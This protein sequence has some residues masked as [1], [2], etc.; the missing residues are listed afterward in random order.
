DNKCGKFEI[1]CGP[2]F[3]GKTEELIRRVRRLIYAKKKYVLFNPKIQKDLE[4]KDIASH[5]GNRLT[6]IPINSAADILTYLRENQ[7]I[8]F[9]A[10]DSIHFLDDYITKLLKALKTKGYKIIATGLD[11]DFRGE[12]FGSMAEL[13]VLADNVTKLSSVCTI[14]GKDAYYTQRVIDGEPASFNDEV[15]D[16]AGEK[17]EARCIEHHELKDREELKIF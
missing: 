9:I 2:M 11:K 16:I 12:A 5:N 14:C 17:Y 8:E 4:L 7:D 13:L 10:I 1:I 15:I 3:S 6:A